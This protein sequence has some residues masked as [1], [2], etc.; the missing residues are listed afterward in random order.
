ML[1]WLETE[2]EAVGFDCHSLAH[3][4]IDKSRPSH[5]Y[6]VSDEMGEN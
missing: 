4:Q 3:P 5:R 1:A 2:I 6:A